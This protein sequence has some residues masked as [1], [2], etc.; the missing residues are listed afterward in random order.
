MIL[1][2][3]APQR[4]ANRPPPIGPDTNAI[5]WSDLVGAGPR[6]GAGA[7][8]IFGAHGTVVTV[9]AG[10]IFAAG[11]PGTVTSALFF[12]RAAAVVSLLEFPLDPPQAVSAM[13]ATARKANFF[14]WF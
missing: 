6:F 5:G 2:I 12:V 3:G 10:A 11:A 13:A 7:G 4:S 1:G 14:I 8:P 9:V